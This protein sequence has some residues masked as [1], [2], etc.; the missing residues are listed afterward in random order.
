M[1]TGPGPTRKPD[2]S[3]GAS[4]D[5]IADLL[6]EEAG[7][8]PQPHPQAEQ[9]LDDSLDVVLET[10]GPSAVGT[11]MP[12]P[13][14]L[15]HGTDEN[16]S[17]AEDRENAEGNSGE[18]NLAY[19]DLLAKLVLPAGKPAEPTAAQTAPTPL[20]MPE[21]VIAPLPPALEHL[22]T[23]A[24]TPAP[25]FRRPSAS[26]PLV[27]SSADERTLVTENPLLAEEQEAAAREGRTTS[28]DA[29]PRV[30][31]EQ[32][33][34]VTEPVSRPVIASGVT[35]AKIV[36][37]FAGSLVM[38]VGV[39]LAL[40]VFKVFVR[41]SSPQPTAVTAPAAVPPPAA[42][43]VEPL[44]SIPPPPAAEPVTAPA[45]APAPEPAA[46]ATDDSP[47]AAEERAAPEPSAKVAPRPHKAAPKRPAHAAAKPA[48]PAAAPAAAKPAPAA[49]AAAPAAKSTKAA[50]AKK[51]K[52]SGY[53]DPFD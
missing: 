26:I 35:K 39:G 28:H 19:E 15:P 50:P 51:S 22:I 47:A 8:T 4:V 20:P 27:S 38:L 16:S 2:G 34:A 45:Q 1:S 37:F 12:P 3:S 53:A 7:K 11:F 13:P 41:P 31:D 21:L 6:V 48:T 46:A 10:P 17:E 42:A 23:P 33:P 29:A 49:K 14:S 40:L 30:Q 18:S 5:D 43:K 32:R 24:P 44:P 25:V 9:A 36:Y 52:S